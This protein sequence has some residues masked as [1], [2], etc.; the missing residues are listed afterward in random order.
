MPKAVTDKLG[1]VQYFEVQVQAGQVI[2]TPVRIQ[3]GDAV[4][5][6]LAELS[7]DEQT[8]HQALAWVPALEGQSARRTKAA[9][10]PVAVAKPKGAAKPTTK[11][12]VAAPKLSRKAAAGRGTRTA[13]K[14]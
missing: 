2:L 7:I 3:R 6:K 8:L 11:A 4:R 9:S 5:A 13:A 12:V 10:T 14:P 1:A